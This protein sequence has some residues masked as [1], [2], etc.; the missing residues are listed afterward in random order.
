MFG[1]CEYKISPAVSL[2][3]RRHVANF[4]LASVLGVDEARMLACGVIEVFTLPVYRAG[5][6]FN[7]TGGGIGNGPRG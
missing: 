4:A 5:A 6:S 1:F 7:N 2:M 3:G